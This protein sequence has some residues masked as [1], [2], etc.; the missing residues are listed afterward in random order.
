MIQE[1]HKVK[2]K[3]VPWYRGGWDGVPIHKA[4]KFHYE[5][6]RESFR[7]N[8]YGLSHGWYLFI[9]LSQLCFL[10]GNLLVG[11]A[12]GVLGAR[13]GERH[14]W[15]SVVRGGVASLPIVWMFT[16]FLYPPLIANVKDQFSAMG[17]EYDD[18]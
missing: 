18:E 4:V 13:K 5:F 10:L 1:A 11:T 6:W 17:H 8:P 9:L 16:L 12:D 7:L 3:Y 2:H 14:A 15:V